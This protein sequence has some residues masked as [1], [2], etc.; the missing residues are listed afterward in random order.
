MTSVYMGTNESYC[1]RLTEILCRS[2]Y[3]QPRDPGAIE[4]FQPCEA[5]RVVRPTINDVKAKLRSGGPC[6][7]TFD[8]FLCLTVIIVDTKNHRNSFFASDNRGA[9]HPYAGGRT[10]KDLAIQFKS[11]SCILLN[12]CKCCV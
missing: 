9:V 12:E 5:H 2:V 8:A 10:F 7:N 3:R 1:G 11:K 6:E 4:T